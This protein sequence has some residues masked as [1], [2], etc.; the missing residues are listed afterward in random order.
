MFLRQNTAVWM[1]TGRDAG[2]H[3]WPNDTT[4]FDPMPLVEQLERQ[5]E[6]N[7]DEATVYLQRLLLACPVD[8]ARS[9]AIR[10]VFTL[11]NDRVNADSLTAAL[12]VLTALPEYQLS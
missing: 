4:P 9:Q 12:C 1:L 5:G 7:P 8:D 2:G 3:P 6:I 11:A 10:H